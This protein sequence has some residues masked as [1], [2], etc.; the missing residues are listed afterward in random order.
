[1]ILDDLARFEVRVVF[2][3]RVVRNFFRVRIRQLSLA[4]G[5]TDLDDSWRRRADLGRGLVLLDLAVVNGHRDGVLDLARGAL[6]DDLL[7]ARL[8]IRVDA[9][10]GLKWGLLSPLDLGRGRVDL[11]AHADDRVGRLLGALSSHG[12]LAG[13]LA[14]HDLLGGGDNLG[15]QLA[16]LVDDLLAGLQVRVEDDLRLERNRLLNLGDDLRILG[17]RAVLDDLVDRVLGLLLLRGHSCLVAL[18]G[19]VRGVGLLARLALLD[20]L[21]LT[22][23]EL[24]VRTGFNFKRHLGSPG[25]LLGD[26]GWLGA[27]LDHLIHRLLGDF[28]SDLRVARLGVDDVT[29]DRHLLLA[30][31]A[32]GDSLRRASRHVRIKLDLHTER[33]F[34][35]HGLGG[36]TGGLRA[37]TDNLLDRLLGALI[38]HLRIAGRLAVH[39]LL[40]R[41]FDLGSELPF[42]IDDL[43][44]LFQGVVEDNFSLK[45]NW[46]LGLGH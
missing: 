11:G 41:S 40:R 17:A 38:S 6:L 5:R 39:N 7:L 28:L 12:R 10:L 44:T 3:Q 15:T 34:R 9:D 4:F 31:L 16:L 33:D 19:E 18:S 37:N 25:D 45:R 21:D 1:M 2:N 13:R 46:L 35:F 42:L 20:D 22:R 43:S 30:W 32:L 8:Q 29:L 23:L 26:L 14:I 36:L 24:R 27:D